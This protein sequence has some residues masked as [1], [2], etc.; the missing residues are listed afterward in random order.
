MTQG[1]RSPG[2]AGE[3][4]HCGREDGKDSAGDNL[5]NVDDPHRPQADRYAMEGGRRQAQPS[6][7]E[8]V[9][10]RFY[11]VELI[12]RGVLAAISGIASCP[13]YRLDLIGQRYTWLI[14]RG[15]GDLQLCALRSRS[16]QLRCHRHDD[17]AI[18]CT[19]ESF[20][21]Q[22]DDRPLSCLL[23]SFRGIEVD[24]PHLSTNGRLSCRPRERCLDDISLPLHQD[25]SLIQVSS[26]D[27]N[28]L[29]TGCPQST[30][31]SSSAPASSSSRSASSE[32]VGFLSTMMRPSRTSNC[33]T[34][35]SVRLTWSATLLGI[36]S[37]RL[38]PQRFTVSSIG[39]FLKAGRDSPQG[40]VR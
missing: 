9:H 1:G 27:P 8:R 24:P 20:G 23:V 14:H 37:A 35:S 3:Q 34:V 25:G 19:I 36:R 16:R 31:G 7:N 13:I 33:T 28:S 4:F 29:P 15:N 30:K 6:T 32:K 2:V 21:G 10:S 26:G 18:R 22:H 17:G 38:F 5:A 11:L 12:V 40:S 39:D